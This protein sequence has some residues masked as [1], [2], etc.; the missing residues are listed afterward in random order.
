MDTAMALG[1]RSR[2]PRVGSVHARTLKTWRRPRT[3]LG[4]H[5]LPPCIHH[6][7][8]TDHYDMHVTFTWALTGRLQ[9]DQTGAAAPTGLWRCGGRPWLKQGSLPSAARILPGKHHLA[10][11]ATRMHEPCQRT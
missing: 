4:G 8:M 10:K 6:C 9:L 7:C 5:T 3:G 11:N 2:C 1:G